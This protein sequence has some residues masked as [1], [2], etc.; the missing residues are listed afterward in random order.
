MHERALFGFAPAPLWPKFCFFAVALGFGLLICG[1]GAPLGGAVR[2]YEHGRYPEAM[3]E[4]R[5]VEAD[6]TH[7]RA[8][9]GARY[10]LYRGL[11]HLALGDI[12]A[13]RYWFARVS[14]AAAADPTV[15]SPED[16]ARLASAWAHLPP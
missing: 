7:W 8:A 10:A 2:A 9:D 6:T 11:A 3:D 1:C 13:T 4:L 5:A 12:A 16:A 15:L 14:G